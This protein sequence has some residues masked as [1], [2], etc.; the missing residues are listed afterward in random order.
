MVTG[1]YARFK[2]FCGAED[3]VRVESYIGNSA[4]AL[5]RKCGA[6]YEMVITALE[7]DPTPEGQDQG[8]GGDKATANRAVQHMIR[9]TEVQL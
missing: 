6:R 5:C 9:R 2:C 3:C 4:I 1:G 8:G 7:T